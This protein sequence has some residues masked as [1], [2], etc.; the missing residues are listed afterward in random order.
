MADKTWFD[1]FVSGVALVTGAYTLYKN[2]IER[3]NVS[4]FPGDRMGIVR[5]PG[6]SRR[7]HLRCVLVNDASKNGTL[8][9]L[10]AKITSPDGS[11]QRYVWNKLF[12]FVPG[13]TDV[14]PAGIPQPIP[15]PVKNSRPLTAQLEFVEPNTPANWTAG[16]HKVEVLGW[17]NRRDRL[18]AANVKSVFHINISAAL[19]AAL[20]CN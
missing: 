5:G 9:R 12:E 17:V 20:P 11:A 7:V 8:Q 6:G 10:E 14:R 1:Y 19:A 13:T 16:R 3:A 4:I 18:R 2:F 15:I